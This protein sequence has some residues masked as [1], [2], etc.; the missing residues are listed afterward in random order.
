MRRAN[1]S[2]TYAT[3]PAAPSGADP[4]PARAPPGTPGPSPTPALARCTRLRGSTGETRTKSATPVTPVPKVAE[5]ILAAPTGMEPWRTGRGRRKQESKR[6]HDVPTGGAV[7]EFVERVPDPA[8]RADAGVTG[9]AGRG[10]D[11]RA[12]GHVGIVDRRVRPQAL[13]IR[14]RAG[15]RRRGDLVRA[16]EERADD[17]SDRRR[18]VL[19]RSAR[20]AG[21]AHGPARGA[22][23][24]PVGGR[25]TGPSFGESS[26][27]V[28]VMP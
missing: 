25:W 24:W 10:G 15:R 6:Q 26:N 21:S 22:C 18:R 2:T 17:V 12:A 28:T 5:L 3:A 9:R 4:R 19:R 13:P 16:A 20:R 23:T 27:G 7:T 1:T 8:I 14:Q 11:R